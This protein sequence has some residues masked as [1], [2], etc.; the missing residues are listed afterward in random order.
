[1]YLLII[2]FE[3]ISNDIAIPGYDSNNPS[4]H[5]FPFSLPFACMRDLPHSPF[6]ALQIQHPTTLGHQSSTGLRASPPIAVRQGHS[7]LQ[8]IWS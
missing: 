8:C 1:M 6:P 4:N 7:L 2:P 5:I 3:Y